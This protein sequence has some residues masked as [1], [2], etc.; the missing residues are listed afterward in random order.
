MLLAIWDKR[1]PSSWSG[2]EVEMYVALWNSGKTAQDAQRA[3]GNCT[4]TSSTEAS[5]NAEMGVNLRYQASSCV[6]IPTLC[7]KRMQCTFVTM[8]IAIGFKEI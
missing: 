7:V 2:F 6:A 4:R 5:P 8:D 1:R 3:S